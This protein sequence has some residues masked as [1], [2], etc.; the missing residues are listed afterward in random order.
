MDK[1]YRIRYFQGTVEPPAFEPAGLCRNERAV[2][3]THLKPKAWESYGVKELE[4][5]VYDFTLEMMHL[6]LENGVNITMV[7]VG[8]ELSNGLLDV[9][10]RL[11][12]DQIKRVRRLDSCD[13][14]L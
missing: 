2:S 10:K 5:A 3:Y 11:D 8:N 14:S 13:R 1:K 6:Y 12:H 9:Y 7:Q 4:Q